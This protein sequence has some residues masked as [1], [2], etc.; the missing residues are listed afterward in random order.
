MD[1]S[2]SSAAPLAND[3]AAASV[4]RRTRIALWAFAALPFFLAVGSQ[5]WPSRVANLPA[6]TG[7]PPLA[8][9]QY[10]VNFHE[11]PVRPEI[12]AFFQ[13]TNRS[14]KPVRITKI[15]PSCGCLNPRLYDGKETY[16]P[17]ERGRFT[18]VV[19]TAR[20]QPGPKEYT[21]RVQY[22][23]E[24]IAYEETMALRLVLPKHKITVEPSEVYFY[25]LTGQPDS[26]TIHVVD[27]RG[28]RLEVKKATINS[29]DA[30]VTLG[31]AELD[32][33]GR[34]R[35]PIRIDVAGEVPP[36]RNVAII[37]IETS[38][39]EFSLLKVPVLIQGQANG[40]V[41][42]SAEVP[43]ALRGASA[44]PMAGPSSVTR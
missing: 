37:E 17:G 43:G 25:Q 42:A 36:G 3:S 27:T 15:V 22:E 24:G 23:S 30:R 38:D 19:K 34:R 18:L 10:V 29:S 26:R 1:G 13:F 2:H 28:G 39:A 44:R 40:V 6:P 7:R 21:A 5:L 31:R 16:E 14:E 12:D 20:E 11:V 9:D 32:D 35:F 8:F 41:P 4:E 33:D